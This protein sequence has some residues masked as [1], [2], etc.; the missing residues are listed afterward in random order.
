MAESA[1]PKRT[2]KVFSLLLIVTAIIFYWVWGISYGSWNLFA[3]ENMGV[4]SI[5]IILLGFGIFGY[6]LTRYRN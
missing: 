5:F 4:Y 3:A 1:Y 6:L 2:L